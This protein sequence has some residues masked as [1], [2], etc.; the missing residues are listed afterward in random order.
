MTA[1]DPLPPALQHGLAQTVAA[2]R[3]EGWRPTDEHLEALTA[4]LCGD[5]GFPAYLSTFLSR[6][7]PPEPRA[8]R[9]ILRR[10]PPYL[11]PGTTVLRNNFGV[12]TAATLAELEYV[13]TA[14]RLALW[15]RMLATAPVDRGGL[16]VRVLHRH[17]FSDVYSWAGEYRITEL[18]RGDTQFA[19][20]STI[21]KTMADLHAQVC[22]LADTGPRFDDARLAFELGRIYARYN[23]IHPFR[24]GNGRAGTLLLHHIAALCGRRLNLSEISRDDWYSASRDSMPL[25]RDGRVSHRP[26]LPLLL[27]AVE[28]R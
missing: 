5:H 1:G 18:R 10:I 13:A 20:R 28:P 15:H 26:F 9:A 11:L 19:W 3:L 6:P 8:T 16:D 2:E 14:G 24:E 7:R 17:V 12:R 22:A 4:L 21:P 25:L 23:R 27:R